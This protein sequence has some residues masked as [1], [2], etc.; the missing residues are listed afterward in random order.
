MHLNYDYYID[1]R[2]NVMTRK[3]KQKLKLNSQFQL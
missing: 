3:K 1:Y 2:Y